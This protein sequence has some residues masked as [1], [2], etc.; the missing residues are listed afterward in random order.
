MTDT[1][2]DCWVLV[3]D[4]DSYS[5]NFERELTAYLTGVI[6]ECGVGDKLA[7]R[8]RQDAK[9]S[10][11]PV[12]FEKLLLQV[13]DEK[14]C[15]RPCTIWSTPGWY[16]DGYGEHYK[17]GDEKRALA[18]S[19]EKAKNEL[20]PR[21]AQHEAHLEKPYAG[22]TKDDV[23]RAIDNLKKDLAK[24]LAVKKPGKYNAY[25]SVAIFFSERPSNKVI[26]WL[27]KR[28]IGRAHV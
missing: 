16:N 9:T 7:A 28:E 24:R 23:K 12:D 22:W 18:A 20:K 27:K 25:L 2:P 14:G 13:P 6:G 1:Y 26:E 17:E 10:K 19:K 11:P 15:A 21:I 5:G 4:T 8:F 3:I